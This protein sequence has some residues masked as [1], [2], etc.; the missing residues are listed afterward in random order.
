MNES[1]II[2]LKNELFINEQKFKLTATALNLFE[3]ISDYMHMYDY[4]PTNSID[5]IT[6]LFSIIKVHIIFFF[7]RFFK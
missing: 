1:K 6:K 4:F 2:I 5:T 3:I 7:S